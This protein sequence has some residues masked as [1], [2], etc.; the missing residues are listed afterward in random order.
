MHI[1]Q[2][3]ILEL[4]KAGRITNCTL[5]EIGEK[6][7]CDHPQQVKHHLFQLQKKGLVNIDSATGGYTLREVKEKGFFNVP[8]M[9]A[10]NCGEA[11]SFADDVAEGFMQ[12]SNSLLP[13][14]KGGL[15]ILR[16]LGQSMDQASINGKNIQDG[17]Y[18][19]I[20]SYKKTASNNKY[21]VAIINGMANIKKIIIDKKNRQVALLSE[22]S[23]DLPPM[24]TH[25]D[26]LE[27]FSVA[28]SVID[29]FKKPRNK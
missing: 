3:N 9:G 23:L 8:I 29:V 7:A 21:I 20:D 10:A 25:T 24:Y 17:D 28:G 15:F 26:D 16:A 19:L 12:I 11:L 27:E 1:F 18:V 14:K 4:T 2:R 5:R 6:I 13:H 22:S